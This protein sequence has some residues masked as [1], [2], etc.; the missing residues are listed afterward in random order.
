MKRMATS[1]G[2]RRDGFARRVLGL[3]P[4]ALAA[5]L[6]GGCSTSTP[7]R[8]YTLSSPAESAPPVAQQV[9]A[10]VYVE[11]APLAL[12]ERL[13]RPQLVIRGRSDDGKPSRIEVLE[14]DQW[15]SSFEYE[16]RDAL[17]NGVA[18]RLGAVN[19]TVGGR[20]PGQAAWRISVEVVQFE[21]IEDQRVEVALGWSM[22]R[23]D[24]GTESSCRWSTSEPV[25]KG[26][27]ALTQGA[28]RAV[29][30]AADAMAR[31]V[32]AL[33]AGRAADCGG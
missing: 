1:R 4:V 11:F 27:D 8:F 12:P 28:Q 2:E 20:P 14:G 7:T 9:A 30:R 22:R 31:H 25:D 13:V 10:P 33:Q 21:P 15:A 3:A 26:I 5:A 29:A 32:A 23:S 24:G 19:T 6:L 17:A 16:L 18:R